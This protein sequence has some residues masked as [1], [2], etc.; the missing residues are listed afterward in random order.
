MRLTPEGMHMH[1]DEPRKVPQTVA[2]LLAAPL[3]VVVSATVGYAVY[4]IYL[5][6]RAR[7]PA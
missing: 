7:R 3:L 2:E 4:L 1:I 5:W 6:N